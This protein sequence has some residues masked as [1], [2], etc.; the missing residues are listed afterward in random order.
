MAQD[1]PGLKPIADELEILAATERVKFN[2]G[3]YL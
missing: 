1:D 3:D 2:R